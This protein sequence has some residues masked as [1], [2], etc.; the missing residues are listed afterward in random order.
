MTTTYELPALP[1][2]AVA[3][4]AEKSNETIEWLRQ[5]IRVGFTS[6]R[7]PAWWANVKTKGGSWEQIPDGSH[8]DGPV[9]MEEV[10]KLL[11]V[12]FAK[13]TVHVTY[14]DESGQ[15]Q[16][17][18]DPAVQPIVCIT[19]GKIFSYPKSGYKIHP[20][21]ETLSDFIKAIQYDQAVAVG[22]VGLLKGGGQAFL[23]AVL[24]Q[25]LE[26]AGY[27]YQPYLLG[28]TSVDLSRSTSYTLAR[29]AR[30]ATTR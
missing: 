27:G 30:S 8:F 10:R 20:Y 16:V 24:P 3:D 4:I 15:R 6:K 14:E 19:T 28:V 7:G 21:L 2:P 11:A 23:Q 22:S 25:T 1:S 18:T 9:P 5:N 12:P 17:A 26:V 13:G 29:W